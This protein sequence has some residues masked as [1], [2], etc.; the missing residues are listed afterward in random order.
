MQPLLG[1]Q[2]PGGRVPHPRWTRPARALAITVGVLALA[3]SLAVLAPL[4]DGPVLAAT[5]RAALASPL[6][7]GLALTAYLGAFLVRAAL[8]RRVVPQLR[9]GQ[10]LAAIHLALAGNHLLPLRLGEA[11][12][13]TSV[14]RRTALAPGA[15]TASTV[16]LRTAD[17]LSVL[18][19]ALLLAPSLVLGLF[20]A[21]GWAIVAALVTAGIGGCWWLIRLSPGRRRVRLPGPTVALGATAAWLLEVPVV[22]Q[23]ARWAGLD[24]SPLQALLVSVVSVAAQVLAIAPGGLGTYEAAAVAAYLMLGHRPGPALAAALAAHTLK[25]AYALAAGAFALVVPTPGLLGRLRL[26][27]R[28]HQPEDTGMPPPRLGNGP[29]VLFLPAHNEVATVAG[30]VAR[31]PPSVCGRRVQCLVVDDGSA[32]ATAR[33]AAAAGA[34][35]VAME[36]NRGLGAAV[37]RGLA[38]ALDRGAA[39]VAFCDA[40]G[41][42]DPTELERLVVPI[43]EGRADYVV[44]SRFAGTIQHMLARRRLGNHLL[45]RALAFV[46]RTPISDGQSGYRAL[47]RSAAAAAVIGHDYNYAQVLTLD[48][49]A[50]GYRYQEVPITY[51]FRATGR[52]F[53]R[54]LQYLRRVIPAVWRELNSPSHLAGLGRA[55]GLAGG[56]RGVGGSRTVAAPAGHVPGRSAGRA[57]GRSQPAWTGRPPLHKLPTD[58]T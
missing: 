30:V 50:K 53:V 29:V 28:S 22:W 35:V 55:Q 21:W 6:G 32:D 4:V 40:D 10:A 12:R 33:A 43:L 23:A 45:T 7:V 3:G 57:A 11:L 19:L 34:Q 8:W 47:S 26:P 14:V 41:E 46:A 2:P 54:P 24:L 18:G 20:G 37:R 39:V 51:R 49:L 42:Y 13:V 5:W 56:P 9:L 17:L 44:G 36:A 1:C 31:V 16:V 15:A 27:P 58:N 52:S 48:L 25:T 38:A